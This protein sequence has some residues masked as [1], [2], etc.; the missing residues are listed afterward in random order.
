MGISVREILLRLSKILNIGLEKNLK[1]SIKIVH[2]FADDIIQTRLPSK[3]E[4]KDED[5]LSRFIRNDD[6]SSQFLCDIII[7]FI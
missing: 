5:L 2:E 7:S 6:N 4:T 3:D 1:M